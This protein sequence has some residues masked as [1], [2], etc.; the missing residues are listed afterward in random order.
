MQITSLL[1]GAFAAA[2]T[3][4]VVQLRLRQR[5]QRRASARAAHALWN[6][7]GYLGNMEINDE[8]GLGD[9][10][11]LLF[12]WRAHEGDLATLNAADHAV[13]ERGVLRMCRPHMGPWVRDSHNVELEAAMCVLEPL[14][15]IP[16]DRSVFLESS[17]RPRFWRLG[18][19]FGA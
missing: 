15:E 9:P 1:I 19:P 4:L 14:A 13:V 7:M 8:D 11:H 12:L 18:R 6:E 5:D 2:G 3:N 16:S 17:T 10:Q